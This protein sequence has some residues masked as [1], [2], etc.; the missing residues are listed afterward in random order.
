ME[1]GFWQKL[2]EISANDI[3]HVLLFLIALPIAKIYK[4]KRKH[5]WL[6]CENAWEAR[7]NAYW[8]YRYISENAPQQDIVYAIKKKSKDYKKVCQLGE[9]VE[10]GSFKH[11]IYYLAAEKNISTQKGGKPNAAVCYFLEVYGFLKNKRYF[12]QHG[13]IMNDLPF[14]HYENS[15]I[16]MFVCSTKRE[17]EYVQEKFHYPKNTVKMLGLCRFDRL[18]EPHEPS[19][20][21]L[22]MPTWRSW[23]SPPSS[24]VKK[25][26]T[27][28]WIQQTEYYKCWNE[29]IN[30]KEM[31]KLLE[32][33]K[34]KLVFY[35]HREMQRFTEL[36][37]SESKRILI[38]DSKH[39]DVQ[40]LLKK[41]DYLV[42]DYSSVAMDF[43]YMK[44]P[45][46]YYQFDYGKFRQMH[47]AEGYFRY[48]VDGFGPVCKSKTEALACVKK[49]VKRNFENEELYLERHK[50][51][52]SL[53]DTCNCRRNYEAIL[54]N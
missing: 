49:A 1:Q 10:Y 39:Y 31:L 35:M 6:I 51:F 13:I 3:M 48:E 27:L 37:Y 17:T 20:V 50:D 25:G 11:W 22:V 29:F 52:F 8:L 43:A 33:Q 21:I 45:L 5:M 44:K 53:Y 23:L 36:F 47:Y 46:L 41:A 16:G 7:D 4:K 32:E 38:A 2:K 14:L 15:K 19:R 24:V 12:L 54:N 42:T 34:L 28:E 9:V 18:H 30:G 40:D 26:E